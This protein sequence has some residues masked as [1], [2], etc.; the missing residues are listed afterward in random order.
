VLTVVSVWSGNKYNSDY[1]K[2]LSWGLAEHLN[3]AYNFVCFTDA[4][5][6]PAIDGVKFCQLPKLSFV[7]KHPW[8]YKIWLFGADSGLTGKVLY[9]D[10]D[11]MIVSNI[12]K[13]VEFSGDFLGIRDF[14]RVTYKS[15]RTTNS[16]MLFWNHEKYHRVWDKFQQYPE[17]I[18]SKFAGDQN[19]ISDEL[20]S[21]ITW[22]PD[23]WAIS[24][25]WEFLKSGTQ[26]ETAVIVFHG[27]PKPHEINWTLST[28]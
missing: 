20:R 8:W 27:S 24:Y 17:Q 12:T 13:F 28:Q 4:S 10:L 14:T 5:I 11:I 25:R 22:W 19:Y 15:T 7:L 1:I 23:S 26:K 21:E 3:C 2:N 6:I 18:Q 16:S 9:L